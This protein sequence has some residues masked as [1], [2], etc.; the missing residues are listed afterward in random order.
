MYR[1]T[2]FLDL[3]Q[4]SKTSRPERPENGVVS[5]MVNKSLFTLNKWYPSRSKKVNLSRKS[6]K[7]IMCCMLVKSRKS[8]ITLRCLVLHHTANLGPSRVT[9]QVLVHASPKDPLSPLNERTNVTPSPYTVG[10]HKHQDSVLRTK[11]LLIL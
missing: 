7:K 3:P 5:V 4:S 9:L 11:Y 10:F 6:A 1:V 8:R 2:R